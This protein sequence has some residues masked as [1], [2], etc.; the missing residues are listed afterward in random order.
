[1]KISKDLFIKSI[2]AIRLQLAEDKVNSSIIAEV[3]D[4][5]DFCLYDNEKLVNAIID[6][7]SVDFDKEDLTHYCFELNFGKP[8]LDSEWETAEMLYDRL[9]KE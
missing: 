1:M 7:L 3:F 4:A 5:K 8:S 6:L 9:T 2:E